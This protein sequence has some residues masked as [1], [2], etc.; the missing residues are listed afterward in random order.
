MSAMIKE[1]YVALKSAG[2]EDAPA[3]AAAEAMAEPGKSI[4]KHELITTEKLNEL[5]I[6][7]ETRFNELVLKIQDVSN[8]VDSRFNE[9]ALKIQDVSNDLKSNMMLVKWMIGFMF[10]FMFVVVGMLW[11]LMPS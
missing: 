6:K 10:T 4:G 7:V 1:V 9:L 5:D 11:R 8:K 3:M 2:V